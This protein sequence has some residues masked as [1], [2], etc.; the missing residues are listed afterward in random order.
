M[1]EFCAV[2]DQDT[3]KIVAFNKQKLTRKSSKG[4]IVATTHTDLFEDLKPSVHIHKQFGK[5]LER[6]KRIYDKAGLK[7]LS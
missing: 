2:L 3:A 6:L 4:V 1:E 7:M 5:E